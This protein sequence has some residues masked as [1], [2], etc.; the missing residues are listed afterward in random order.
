M[1]VFS[2]GN[3]IVEAW[4]MPWGS[5]SWK[6]ER[7]PSS[8]LVCSYLFENGSSPGMDSGPGGLH[9]SV[10]GS[11]IVQ[12]GK[13]GAGIYFNSSWYMY[14]A[15]VGSLL[16]S[17]DEVSFSCFLKPSATTSSYGAICGCLTQYTYS[18]AILQQVN[19]G[20]FRFFGCH[21]TLNAGFTLPLNEWSHVC[22]VLEGSVAKVYVNGSLVAEDSCT[23]SYYD[24]NGAG[25]YMGKLGYASIYPKTMVDQLRVYG[26][27]LTQQEVLSLSGEA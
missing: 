6:R 5:D 21:D 9:L 3:R 18:G 25:F 4:G 10:Y 22:A 11:P 19:D 2:V 27:A 15:E 1:A 12:P 7:L 13:V 17:L 20:V 26:R 14:S 8:G 16:D 24:S 23:M